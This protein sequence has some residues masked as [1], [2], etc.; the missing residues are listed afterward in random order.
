VFIG[1]VVLLCTGHWI[2]LDFRLDCSD[3]CLL[4]RAYP[5]AYSNP[6]PD[7][8]ADTNPDTN[9]DTNADTSADTSAGADTRSGK[10]HT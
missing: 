10:R 8:N 7:T 5:D 6:N 1:I 2:C 4:R 9:P 3:L